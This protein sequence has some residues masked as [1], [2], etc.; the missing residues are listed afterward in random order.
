MKNVLEIALN[1]GLTEHLGHP[2]TIPYPAVS[3]RMCAVPATV[4]FDAVGEVTI[5]VPRDPESTFEPQ[6]VKKR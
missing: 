3:P 1:E 5:D 6:I 2:N 4:I